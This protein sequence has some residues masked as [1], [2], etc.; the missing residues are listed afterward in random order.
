MVERSCG[1]EPHPGHQYLD[2]DLWLKLAFLE[3]AFQNLL[4]PEEQEAAIDEILPMVINSYEYVGG[5]KHAQTP[6][7]TR[8]ALM[9]DVGPNMMWKVRSVKGAP[10]AVS[11]YKGHRAP[12]KKVL[13]AAT[14]H[15]RAHA[16][17][18]LK[19]DFAQGRAYMEVSGKSETL[20]LRFGGVPVP[21][22]EVQ[23]LLGKEI[24]PDEDDPTGCHY[25]RLIG[26][27]LTRKLLVRPH[28]FRGL[29]R[30]AVPAH[31]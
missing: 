21:V 1:F 6:E 16:R 26:G 28:L 22:G 7:E 2:V 18:M 14:F 5:Y 10:V 24:M 29:P 3:E 12:R 4:T 13:S 9:Q 15:G 17:D 11:I 19:A 27:K 20:A 30:S 23:Q 8:A 31:G 25:Y